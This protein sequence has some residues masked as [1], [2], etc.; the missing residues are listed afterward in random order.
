VR[1]LVDP[2][3]FSEGKNGKHQQHRPQ[4]DV[5]DYDGPE[6]QGVVLEQLSHHHWVLE[7][8]MP[9]PDFEY[10]HAE[11]GKRKKNGEDPDGACSDS[12]DRFHW[13]TPG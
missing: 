5:E 13:P 12:R 1:T 2:R 11:T 6:R 9:S 10:S 7:G 4:E 3:D 8:G